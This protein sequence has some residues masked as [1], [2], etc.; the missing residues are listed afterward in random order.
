VDDAHDGSY[1]REPQ[2]EDLVRLARAL[3]AHDVQYVLIGGFAVIAHGGAR[4]TKDIDLLIDARPANVARVREALRILEDKAVDD[5]ADDDVAR[6]TVV[7]I[8]D[9][10]V[11]DLMAKACG[12]DYDDASRDAV[13]ILF[14]DVPVP[15]ASPRTLIR[16]KNTLRPS[17]AADRQFLQVLID[18]SG[19]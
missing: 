2:L 8:A 14:G 18:E 17:D 10:I 5:V 12:V 11:V 16:T 15:V 4:T 7:R 9:E 6:Y 19:C 1:A 3:N 13:V